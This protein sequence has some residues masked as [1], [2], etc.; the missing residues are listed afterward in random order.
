MEDEKLIET[1]RGFP[2]LWRLSSKAYKDV[3]AKENAWK[4]VAKVNRLTA[5]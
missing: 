2:C 4:E 1:V 3:R 5:C